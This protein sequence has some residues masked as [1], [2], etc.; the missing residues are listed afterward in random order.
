MVEK[1]QKRKLFLPLFIAFIMVFSIFG[2]IIGSFSDTGIS[3]IEYKGHTFKFDRDRWFTFID[4]QRIET[5][6]DPRE[7]ELVYTGDL[8]NKI[9]N[10][11]KI[12]L[13]VNP[14]DGLDQE[15]QVYKQILSQ[16]TNK[17]VVIACPE[18]IEMCENL[19][20][21]NCQD[22]LP[23]QILVI[24][25][26]TGANSLQE[27]QSCAAIIGDNTHIFTVLEKIRLEYL[28]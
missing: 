21:K 6:M 7:L 17:Q 1:K 8:F 22:S 15:S 4:E 14:N 10:H 24:K 28:L 16:I 25:L 23:G 3:D 19:P 5:F 18:D 26:E 12:Y 9:F 13:S 20:V 27:D 11:Q 2:V